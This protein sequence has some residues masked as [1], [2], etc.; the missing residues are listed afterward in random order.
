[1]CTAET[2]LCLLCE[3]KVWHVETIMW[4]R[5]PRHNL[6]VVH[7]ACS[8]GHLH[9]AGSDPH[10]LCLQQQK[11]H[12]SWPIVWLILG[13]RLRRRPNININDG[14]TSVWCSEW[15]PV[16][17]CWNREVNSYSAEILYK[18]RRPKIF[19][20]LKLSQM[21]RLAFSVSFEYLS[22]ASTSILNCLIL[23][24]RGPTLD[25]RFWRLKDVP[26]LKGLIFLHQSICQ[27]SVMSFFSTL[28]T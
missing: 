14:L 19:F 27:S 15:L 5:Q 26:V 16:C 7:C 6:S 18:P 8:Q 10:S 1:M 12:G 23:S 11:T 24:E 20:Y 17:H 4:H 22:Y 25:V 2:Y 3:V 9:C 13:Q 21:T 28:Y